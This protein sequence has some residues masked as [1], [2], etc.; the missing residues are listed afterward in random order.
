MQ[1]E[2]L[3][4]RVSAAKYAQHDDGVDE[5]LEARVN[6]MITEGWKP[7]GG[8]CMVVVRGDGDWSSIMYSQA[9]IK[10]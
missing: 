9:L 5:T 2:I 3:T 6:K 4:S 10:E 8:V 1:Y 7:L